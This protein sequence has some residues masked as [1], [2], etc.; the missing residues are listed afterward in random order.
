MSSWSRVC[1]ISPSSVPE[2][3]PVSEAPPVAPPVPP[4]ISGWN[5]SCSGESGV[6]GPVPGGGVIGL[7]GL[8]SS[9]T[10]RS[11]VRSRGSDATMV[12]YRLLRRVSIGR[13]NLVSRSYFPA[14]VLDRQRSSSFSATARRPYALL[15]SRLPVCSTRVTVYRSPLIAA[16][17]G[18]TQ[19]SCGQRYGLTLLFGPRTNAQ[20]DT[21]HRHGLTTSPGH[22]L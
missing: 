19:S 21:R 15:S 16:E 9:A 4:S 11:S 7:A 8:S 12:F 13:R 18:L 20:L 17:R 3:P 14:R 22:S 2:A 5:R 10:L 6:L 1:I